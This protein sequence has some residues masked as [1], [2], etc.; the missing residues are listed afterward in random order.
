MTGIEPAR[1]AWELACQGRSSREFA[2]QRLY[3]RY[4]LLTAIHRRLPL[5]RARSGHAI[6]S[7]PWALEQPL[8]GS[9]TNSTLAR[10]TA[11][12]ARRTGPVK[13]RR[14]R[15]RSD[16]EGALDWFRE[17]STILGWRWGSALLPHLHRC[18]LGSLGGSRP[19]PSLRFP[20]S[21]WSSWSARRPATRAVDAGRCRRAPRATASGARRGRRFAAPRS[22]QRERSGPALPPPTGV[23]R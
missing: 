10:S 12:T 23:A 22:K 6:G 9:L 5:D 7:A 2:G 17:T 4:P 15:S 19:T 18:H 8:T 21:W 3:E 20:A 13:G 11:R 14:S 16:A 1:S